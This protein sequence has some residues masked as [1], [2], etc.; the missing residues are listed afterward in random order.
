MCSGKNAWI[1]FQRGVL[2]AR[3]CP[4]SLNMALNAAQCHGRG[5]YSQHR[6][7]SYSVPLTVSGSVGTMCGVPSPVVLYRCLLPRRRTHLDMQCPLGI[8]AR[9][10]AGYPANQCCS[11][12]LAADA[13]ADAGRRRRPLLI[14]DDGAFVDGVH[15]EM[16]S[17][18][19]CA[20]LPAACVTHIFMFIRT[21]TSTS[22]PSFAASTCSALGRQLAG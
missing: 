10:A 4:R 9:D 8:A 14:G 11:T 7:G 12:L 15:G 2:S 3:H 19:T 6:T 17:G 5:D 21:Y 22:R 16:S 20:Q 13:A 1:A 18:S